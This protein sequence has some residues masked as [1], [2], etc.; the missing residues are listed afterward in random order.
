VA[1]VSLLC[2]GVSIKHRGR[3]PAGAAFSPWWDAAKWVILPE[4]WE[5][6]WKQETSVLLPEAKATA[7]ARKG[8]G[9]DLGTMPPFSPASDMTSFSCTYLTKGN[10]WEEGV[11]SSS[12]MLTAL[13][14]QPSTPRRVATTAT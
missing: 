13:E 12:L 3:R 7:R 1:H 8:S 11:R 2:L 6:A 4:E 5:V 10:R 9:M 14:V